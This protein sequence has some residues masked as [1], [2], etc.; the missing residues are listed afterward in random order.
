MK[1]FAAQFASL[2]L[3]LALGQAGYAA[4]DVAGAVV[5]SVKAIDRSGKVVVVE[6][7]DG[8]DHAFH[9]TGTLAVHT[10]TATKT[11]STDTV[12]GIDRGSK[13]VVHYS[14]KGSKETAHEI[15]RVG[16]GGLDVVK[17]TVTHVDKAA[18]TVSIKTAD[19]SEKVFS[20]TAQASKDAGL[21]TAAG[22]DK[23]A[24]VSAYYTEEAG[25]KTVHFLEYAF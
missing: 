15:D 4:Q 2:G 24:K 18:R 9:Y 23:G 13:V 3:L 6:S 8:V 25:K 17:G 16:D 22:A 20:M 14:V 21:K 5:G 1:K 12:A 10:A 19:G 7:A 11:A